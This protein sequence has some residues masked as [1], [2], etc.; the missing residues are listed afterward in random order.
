MVLNSR[1]AA[2]FDIADGAHLHVNSP[3]EHLIDQCWILKKAD[4]MPDTVWIP[5]VKG[6][7]DRFGTAPFTGVNFDSHSRFVQTGKDMPQWL[8]R[9]LLFKAGQADTGDEIFFEQT[10]DNVD[11]GLD[12]LR[13]AVPGNTGHHL[14]LDDSRFQ[15]VDH[16]TKTAHDLG[17]LNRIPG[18]QA[19]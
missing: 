13:R 9:M 10:F 19:R 6:V 2:G 11:T 15:P 17:C 14:H 18:N 3:L 8:H 7:A 1:H 12:F 5:V 16:P 4:S